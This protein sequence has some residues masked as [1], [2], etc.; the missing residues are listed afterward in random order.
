ME[1]ARSLIASVHDAHTNGMYGLLR[2]A[3]PVIAGWARNAAVSVGVEEYLLQVQR[4]AES[5]D[6]AAVP[7]RSCGDEALR[8]AKVGRGGGYL[9]GDRGIEIVEETDITVPDV[10][11]HGPTQVS[12]DCGAACCGTVAYASVPRDALEESCRVGNRVSRE[13]GVEVFKD[14]TVATPPPKGQVP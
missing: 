3:R 1:Q 10:T 13:A 14:F 8:A 6:G 9:F 2:G 4:V 11:L 12:R 5:V 7:E